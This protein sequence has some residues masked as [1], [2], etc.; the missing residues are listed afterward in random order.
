MD[1]DLACIADELRALRGVVDEIANTLRQ[2]GAAQVD[3]LDGIR[4]K[5][6]TRQ[7]FA[8]VGSDGPRVRP[9]QHRE[10]V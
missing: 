10:R 9:F 2:N 1:S 5:L 3:L 8:F 7:G 4:R 6:A